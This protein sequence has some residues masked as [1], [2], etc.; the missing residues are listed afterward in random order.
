VP[1][2]KKGGRYTTARKFTFCAFHNCPQEELGLWFT[3]LEREHE[4]EGKPGA[5]THARM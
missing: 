3:I 5:K 2:D 1:E 4:M